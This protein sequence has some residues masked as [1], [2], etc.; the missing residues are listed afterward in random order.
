MLTNYVRGN[1]FK[2][3]SS[4]FVRYWW[5]KSTILACAVCGCFCNSL[6]TRLLKCNISSLHATSRINSGKSSSTLC[7]SKR[8]SHSAKRRSSQRWRA[9]ALRSGDSAAVSLSNSVLLLVSVSTASN[10]YIPAS[11]ISSNKGVVTGLSSS[12]SS[13]IKTAKRSSAANPS[14]CPLKETASSTRSLNMSKRT[15]GDSSWRRRRANSSTRCWCVSLFL[16]GKVGRVG[17]AGRACS[18]PLK[19]QS[20]VTSSSLSSAEIDS[21][22]NLSRML[23]ISVNKTGWRTESSSNSWMR[24][25]LLALCNRFSSSGSMI[26]PSL[27]YNYVLLREATGKVNVN[28]LPCPTQLSTV[29]RPPCASTTCRAIASPKPLPPPPGPMKSVFERARSAL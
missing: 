28:V 25:S 24:S 19:S 20:S 9:C 12:S 29:I 16:G 21:S 18:S 23:I 4:A 27:R 1:S 8:L 2:N 26:H 6:C 10:E 15:C 13:S 17:N 3:F 11:I 14:F 22:G 7:A 5:L